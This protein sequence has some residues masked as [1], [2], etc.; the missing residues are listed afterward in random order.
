MPAK[1]KAQQQ[2]FGMALAVRRGE[3][4][5]SD[6]DK[7]VLDIVDSNM[8]DK[9]IRDFAKTKHKGLKDHVKESLK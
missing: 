9:Q 7:D 4:K 6:A 3:M 2:L 1:S 5:R 8:T